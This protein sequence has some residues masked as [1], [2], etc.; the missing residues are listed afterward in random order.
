MR[1]LMIALFALL[2]TPAFAQ[3]WGHY[4]NA[5]FGFGIDIPPGFA[6]A[7]EGENGDGQAF[8]AEGKPTFVLVW[9]GNLTDGFESGVAEAMQFTQDEGWNISYQAATPDWASFSA[10]KG[11]RVLYQRMVLLCDGASY[12]SF[13]AEYSAV[14]VGDMNPVVERLV[15]SLRGNC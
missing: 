15:Q 9:A 2:A 13:L 1:T 14:D 4:D 12:A 10:V 3:D 6:G 8:K 7:G 5:R 11:S